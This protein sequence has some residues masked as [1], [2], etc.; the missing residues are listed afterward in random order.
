MRRLATTAVSLVVLLLGA[1]LISTRWEELVAA[2][3]RIGPTRV[4][5]TVTLS[6]IGII[7][8]GECWR[9]WLEA[10]APGQPARTALRLF[11][12]T[13]AGKYV[14]GAIWPMVAQLSLARRFGIPR[15]AILGATALFLTSHVVT[16]AALGS[17]ALGIGSATWLWL[18]IPTVLLGA[19]ALS[20][21]IIQLIASILVKLTSGPAHLP[22]VQVSVSLTTG[23]LMVGA[24]LAFGLATQILLSPF[25]VGLGDFLTVVGAFSLSW[26][27]GFLAILA[28]AGVG[29]RE[30]AFVALLAP[31]VGT[32]PALAAAL[33]SRIAFII[34][35]VGLGAISAAVLGEA[36]SPESRPTD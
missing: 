36:V 24:W 15:S 17:L 7:A 8:T 23:S 20:P 19:I 30:G 22:R 12:L 33:L 32:T 25:G 21:R 4:T 31:V 10:L 2:T 9:R 11:F 14:P 29:A 34:G 13:Q 28:P 35:D 27:A 3:D 26:V 5:A 6:V 1:W 16:G 18:L